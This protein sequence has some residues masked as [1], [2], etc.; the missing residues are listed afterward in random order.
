MITTNDSELAEMC[1]MMRSHGMKGRDDHVVLGYNYRMTEIEAAIGNVQLRKLEDFN[2]KRRENSE[3]ILDNLK[4]VEWIGIQDSEPYVDH[5]YFW[6]PIHV[7]E[8]VIGMTTGEVRDQLN[9][10]G[11][12]T[13]QR[14]QEPLYRQPML[15]EDSPYPRN[16]DVTCPYYGKTVRYEDLNF[17]NAEKYAGK[18]LGLPNH[19]GLDRRKLDH[20]VDAVRSIKRKES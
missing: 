14:Y 6:C 2:T 13:R 19:P 12:G 5:S 9:E 15:R 8:D 1:R 7:K 16:Y 10:M 11:V 4:D 18:L 17:P 20:V 3:Y